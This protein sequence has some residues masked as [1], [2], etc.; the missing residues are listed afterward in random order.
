LA[1][2]ES[3]E[4]LFEDD[5]IEF[6]RRDLEGSDT[7]TRRRASADL[8]RGLLTL[9]EKQV[10]DIFSQHITSYLAV[11]LHLTADSF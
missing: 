8:V 3:D 11:S 1:K 10:T 4:E 5:P 9:F 6:I 2:I 7:E